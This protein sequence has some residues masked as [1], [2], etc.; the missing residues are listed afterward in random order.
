MRCLRSRAARWIVAAIVA[1]AAAGNTPA[2]A[3]TKLESICT[4][5]GQNEVRLVGLGLVTGLKGTGDGG[6]FLPMIQGLGMALR[7]LN[8]PATGAPELKD[9]SNVALVLVEATIPANG[10]RRGQ[11]IDCFVNSIGAAKSLRGGRLMVSP[12]GSEIIDDDKVMG[13]ASGGVLLEDQVVP[14]A[15]RIPGGVVVTEDVIH[16]FIQNN[17]FMLLLDKDH[18]TFRSANEVAQAVNKDTAFEYNGEPVAKAISPGS[19]QVMIPEAYRGDEMKFIAQVLDVGIDNPHTQAR[20]VLNA[21]A[22]T[23]VVTG[24]V[25]ISPV[26]I[27]HKNLTLNIG[28]DDQAAQ[29]AEPVPGVGFAPLMDQQTR[30]SPQ[31][32]NQLISALNQLKVPTADVIDI[33]KELHRAGKLHA[34]LITE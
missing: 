6:K 3:R 4:I 9:T 18:A 33:L 16:R 8:N 15:G 25:E 31:K 23:V 19:V 34:E 7:K 5:S 22:G 17:H 1:L 29:P 24:E 10:I 13:L 2:H 26:A 20:V 30:Q 32:L 27:S 14:T 28:A 12:L 11:R 21:K